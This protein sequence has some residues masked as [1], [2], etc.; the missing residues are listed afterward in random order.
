VRARLAGYKVPRQVVAVP[1][2]T[3]G[4]NGKI[5]I[6]RIRALLEQSRPSLTRTGDINDQANPG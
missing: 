4:P 2:V 6:P 1:E 5:D 3:R